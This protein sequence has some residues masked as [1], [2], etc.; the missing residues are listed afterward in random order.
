MKQVYLVRQ[1]GERLGPYNY[2]P[3]DKG[4]F[5]FVEVGIYHI[6]EHY[7]YALGFRTEEALPEKITVT[8][9]HFDR[10]FAARVDTP[11]DIWRALCEEAS[12]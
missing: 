5:G 9:E 2:T 11:D 6:H 12:R 1:N 8:R 10:A 4:P 3:P 7:T